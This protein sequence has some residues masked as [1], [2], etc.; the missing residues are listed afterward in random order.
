MY[1]YIYIYIPFLQGSLQ[2]SVVQ[3]FRHGHMRINPKLKGTVPVWEFPWAN[4]A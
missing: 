2:G 1:V 3:L 4:Q